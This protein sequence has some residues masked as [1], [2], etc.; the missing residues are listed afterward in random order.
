MAG[1]NTPAPWKQPVTPE[2][3][4]DEPRMLPRHG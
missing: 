2:A 1:W 4:L 3:V